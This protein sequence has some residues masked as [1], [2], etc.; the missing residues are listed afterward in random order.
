MANKIPFNYRTNNMFIWNTTNNIISTK[1]LLS[2]FANNLDKLRILYNNYIKEIQ[3]VCP[4]KLFNKLFTDIIHVIHRTEVIVN[5]L[6]YHKWDIKNMSHHILLNFV[7][8]I[9]T[10]TKSD[11]SLLNNNLD[12]INKIKTINANNIIKITNKI[13]K[14]FE[15]LKI[16]SD[17]LL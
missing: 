16:K 17:K 8:S 7:S 5:Y 12:K 11:S 14:E 1:Q 2:R 4:L 15:K 3:L 6:Y 9:S 10:Y 13:I